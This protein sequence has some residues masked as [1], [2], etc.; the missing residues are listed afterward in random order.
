M[1]RILLFLATNLAIMLVL[2]GLILGFAA[3]GGVDLAQQSE[4]PSFC[5]H[6]TSSFDSIP[7][8]MPLS[9]G[10]VDGLTGLGHPPI[11][12]SSFPSKP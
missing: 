12:D 7:T 6:G 9:L 1:K 10:V 3:S 2:F 11:N 8:F 4:L 5:T